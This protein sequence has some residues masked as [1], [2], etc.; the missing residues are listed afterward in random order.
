MNTATNIL[1]KAGA[2][3]SQIDINGNTPLD[4]AYKIRS[5]DI[6]HILIKNGVSLNVNSELARKL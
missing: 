4:I 2:N 6:L 1:I 5:L 3:M